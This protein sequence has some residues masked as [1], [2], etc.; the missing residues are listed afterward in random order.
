MDLNTASCDASLASWKDSLIASAPG[1]AMG[2]VV[3][4]VFGWSVMVLAFGLFSC[5][6][7]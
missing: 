6:G 3:G 5:V 1:A 2:C 4:D 7:V